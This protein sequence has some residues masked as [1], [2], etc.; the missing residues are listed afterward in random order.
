ML[1]MKKL[2]IGLVGIVAL[3]AGAAELKINLNAIVVDKYVK[4]E[5]SEDFLNNS[6]KLTMSGR[7]T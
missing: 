2:L 3:N 1:K 6:V 5:G 7:F 4:A